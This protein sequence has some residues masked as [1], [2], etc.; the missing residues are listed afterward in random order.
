[1]KFC[2]NLATAATRHHLPLIIP[3]E[4]PITLNVNGSPWHFLKF[5]HYKST[6]ISADKFKVHCFRNG[7]FKFWITFGIH[8]YITLLGSGGT[9]TEWKIL[10]ARGGT[11][12]VSTIL[13]LWHFWHEFSM[14]VTSKVGIKFQELFFISH[15]VIIFRDSV[16]FL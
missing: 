16:D 5:R 14:P 1:M 6:A 7:S 9:A 11:R 13:T 12:H 15:T 2:E 3:A 8:T 4:F 10:S